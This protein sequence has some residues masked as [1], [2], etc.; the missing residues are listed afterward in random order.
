MASRIGKNIS[1]SIFGQSH[2]AGVGC[3]VEGIPAGKKIGLDELQAF[4]SR[5]APGG[6]PW[7]TPRKEADLPE[8]LGGLVNGVTCGAPLA[9][10]IRNTNTKSSDYD[11]LRRVP[12]PGHAD[13]VANMKFHGAQDVS[14]GGHFSGRLTA[15]LCIAGGIA[16]QLLRDEGVEVGAHIARIAGIADDSFALHGLSSTDVHVAHAKTFPVLNDAQGERMIAAIVEAREAGDSV[17]GIVECAATGMPVGVGEPMFDG[18]ENAVARMLFGIP[19]VKGVE[20]G[21]G[22]DVADMRGSENNDG[23]RIEDGRVVFE[24]NNAGGANGGITTGEPVVVRC[25]FKPTPSIS[26]AQHSIDMQA[27]TNEG[28]SVHGRHDPCVVV[29]AV[30]VV[31]AAVALALY[32]LLLESRMD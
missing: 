4:L 26:R 30:P 9:A 27:G 15:P 7:S 17:G 1:V 22:F 3:V 11:E 21:R 31:E 29:R 5:R 13:Y 14:G 18:V 6:M 8:F 25:A 2:S 16:I 19:A 20:F 24:S 12:R 32:D 28:L 10:L 23:M